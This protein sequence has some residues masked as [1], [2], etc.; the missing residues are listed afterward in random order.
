MSGPLREYE[1]RTFAMFESQFKGFR[2]C[3]ST[4][5]PHRSAILK[6]KDIQRSDY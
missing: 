2:Q 4:A 1:V 6:R 3:F 5:Q